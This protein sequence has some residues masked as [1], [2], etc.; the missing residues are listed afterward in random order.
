MPR[1]WGGGG[2]GGYP[3]GLGQRSVLAG[4]AR[5]RAKVAGLGLA[6]LA[7]GLGRPL[8]CWPGLGGLGCRPRQAAGLRARLEAELWA[9][10]KYIRIAQLKNIYRT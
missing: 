3:G 9:A 2:V 5:G 8:G 10:D 1:G 6:G 4:W 7:N